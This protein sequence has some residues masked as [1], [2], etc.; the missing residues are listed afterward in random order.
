MRVATYSEGFTEKIVA[1]EGLSKWEDF[2]TYFSG[3]SINL[4]LIKLSFLWSC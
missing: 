3:D 1:T 4:I 2:D